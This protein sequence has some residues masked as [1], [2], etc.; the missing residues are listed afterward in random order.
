[1]KK[2]KPT[3]TIESIQT[4]CTG[5]DEINESFMAVETLNNQV[6]WTSPL[7][8]SKDEVHKSIADRYGLKYEPLSNFES[9]TFKPKRIKSN[10]TPSKRLADCI[11][12]GLIFIL[13]PLSAYCQEYAGIIQV[14]KMMKAEST[15]YFGSDSDSAQYYPT[16]KYFIDALNYADKKG[17]EPISIYNNGLPQAILRRKE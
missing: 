14:P 7:F 9:V 11:K 2:V 17:W 15:F 16:F 4:S 5:S 6:I 3:L 13:F 12:K 10:I 1:M 8:D